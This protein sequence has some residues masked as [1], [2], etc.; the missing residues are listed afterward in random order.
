[1]HRFQGGTRKVAAVRGRCH[2]SVCP[3]A[4]PAICA[5][6]RFCYWFAP[7]QRPHTLRQMKA[8]LIGIVALLHTG[9][10]APL[11]GVCDRCVPSAIIYGV[12]RDSAG[13]HVPGAPVDIL[14]QR[15]ACPSSPLDG[16]G[17]RMNAVVTTAPDGSYRA[18]VTS[19]FGPFTATCLEFMVDPLGARRS[20]GSHDVR[21][22]FR[23]DFQ[24]QLDSVRVDLRVAPVRSGAATRVGAR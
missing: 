3:R 23:P 8:L 7:V 5:I 19:I 22:A 10:L 6:C 11:L 21:L 24:D 12:V 15:L 9:C 1:M 16:G 4:G 18:Q 17:G 20:G 14:I 2:S 13:I